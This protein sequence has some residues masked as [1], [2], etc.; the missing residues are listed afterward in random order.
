MATQK[1]EL[2]SAEQTALANFASALAHPARIAII[3][4]LQQRGE[5]SC[6]DLVEALPLAQP[7]VSQHIKQLREA[8]L[9]TA[10]NCG[11]KICYSINY[12]SLRHFCHTFQ[13]TLGTAE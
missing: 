8:D 11:P 6:G 4:Q 3:T 9:L 7:T 5:A 13:C 2:F 1:T 10:R 12:E